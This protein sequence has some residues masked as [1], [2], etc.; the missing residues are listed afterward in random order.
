MNV[1]SGIELHFNTASRLLFFFFIVFF[2]LF[3]F[4]LAR[5]PGPAAPVP[6]TDPPGLP[7]VPP[8]VP[9]RTPRGGGSPPAADGGRLPAPVE[10]RHSS[11]DPAAAH[12]EGEP[13]AGG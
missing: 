6:P 11:A 9:G 4:R 7:D 13:E 3:F 8:L 1:L 5:G 2:Y 12:G 10:E